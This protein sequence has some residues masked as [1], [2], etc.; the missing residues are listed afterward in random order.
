MSCHYG[1]SKNH[2]P[3]GRSPADCQGQ[4]RME[5]SLRPVDYWGCH[6]QCRLSGAY[7][8]SAQQPSGLHQQQAAEAHAV[9][10]D[11]GHHQ[12]TLQDVDGERQRFRCRV[13]ILCGDWRMCG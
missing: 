12:G 8:E 9:H 4:G 13:S 5:G 10:R 7:R 6:Y 3:I 11:D 2:H 1:K